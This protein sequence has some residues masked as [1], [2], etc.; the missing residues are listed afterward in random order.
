MITKEIVE[1][2]CRDLSRRWAHAGRPGHAASLLQVATAIQEGDSGTILLL[3][4]TLVDANPGLREEFFA[5][6]VSKAV[7]L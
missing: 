2:A 3:V 1:E 7:G 4:Q 6:V 5:A